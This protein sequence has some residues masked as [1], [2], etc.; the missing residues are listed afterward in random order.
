MNRL[1]GNIRHS[2]SAW[3]YRGLFTDSPTVRAPMTFEAYCVACA[4]LGLESVELLGPADWPAVRKA[5]LICALC[6]GPSSIDYGWNRVEHH[7]D[8]LGYFGP[9]LDEAARNG[10]PNMVTFSGLRGG[11]SDEEGLENCVQGLKRLAP[12]AERCGVTLALELL[13]SKVDHPDYMAD[14]TA[15]GVELCKRVGS[16]RVKLLY[17]IYHMQVMEGDLLRTIGEASPYIAHYHT[18]GNPGRAEIDESQ[19]I[20]YPAVMQAIVATGYKGYVGQ[21]FIPRRDPLA[22]LAQAIAICDV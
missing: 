22:S 20:Y 11:M 10:I 5:G 9:A 19:E 1:K 18:G 8:L 13:N 12:L 2:V 4:G 14:H 7:D 17:D 3:C 15:W 21:E 6:R 16:E